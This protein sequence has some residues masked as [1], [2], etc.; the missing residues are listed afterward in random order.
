M[1]AGDVIAMIGVASVVMTGAFSLILKLALNGSVERSRNALD[2]MRSHIEQQR[3]DNA[4]VR[5]R[6]Q[7]IGEEVSD[8]KVTVGTLEM[9]VQH[10]EQTVNLLSRS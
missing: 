1:T 7:Q 6:L 3:T 9:K 10:I 4:W 5:D 2:L 8:V